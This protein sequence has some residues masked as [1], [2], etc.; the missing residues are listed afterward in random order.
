MTN[1]C[2]YRPASYGKIFWYNPSQVAPAAGASVHR[3][4]IGQGVLHTVVRVVRVFRRASAHVAP[5]AGLLAILGAS[6]CSILGLDDG[7]TPQSMNQPVAAPEPQQT[8]SVPPLPP[9][10]P[11]R[12]APAEPMDLSRLVG[13]DPDDVRKLL[14]APDRVREANPAT[15]WAYASNA[16]LLE[17]YFYMDLGSQ[18]LRVLAYDINTAG[19]AND[20]RAS[21]GCANQIRAESRDGKR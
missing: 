18:K 15:V 14:G 20:Q 2:H 16:C 10:R 3:L 4:E 7:E 12:P 13:L 8:A 1:L 6:G 11:T 19:R 17:V 5:V 21:N 9:R